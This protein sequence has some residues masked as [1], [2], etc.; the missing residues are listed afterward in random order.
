MNLLAREDS[1]RGSGFSCVLLAVISTHEMTR[2]NA[3][4]QGCIVVV[5]AAR[6]PRPE[7]PGLR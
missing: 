3:L 2:A 4:S 1:Y 5:S 6:P 7:F